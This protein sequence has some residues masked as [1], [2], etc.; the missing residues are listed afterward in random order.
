MSFILNYMQANE[1]PPNKGEAR[2]VLKHAA[3]YTLLP[4]NFIKW[5]EIL[6][7]YGVWS[8]MKSPWYH[9]KYKKYHAIDILAKKNS[10]TSC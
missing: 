10:P 2:R 3:K 6:Q 5:G 1:L 7:C 4:G 8:S 9:P